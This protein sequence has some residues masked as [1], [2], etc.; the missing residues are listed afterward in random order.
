MTPEKIAR[1]NEL[2]KKQKAGTL[3][4]A[5]KEEQAA[6]RLEYRQSVVGNLRQQLN[7]VEFVEPDGKKTK[8]CHSKKKK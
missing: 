8:P 5:E 3:T 1:I 7:N 6:L 4:D 2:A